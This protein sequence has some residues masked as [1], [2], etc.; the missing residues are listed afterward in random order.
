MLAVLP[1]DEAR[2][3]TARRRGPRGS[4]EYA[5]VCLIV[6]NNASVRVVVGDGGLLK[7]G[8]MPS[9]CSVE[10]MVLPRIGVSLSEHEAARIDASVAAHLH[11]EL[12]LGIGRLSRL[13]PPAH[14]ATAPDVHDEAEVQVPLPSAGA[15]RQHERMQ[16]TLKHETAKPRVPTSSRSRNA[17][18]RFSKSSTASGRRRRSA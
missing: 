18:T 10:T 2:D 12:D 4:C 8:T 3:S 6:R 11:D 9:H 5:G 15:R 1:S 16:R 14:D 17:S 7:K 13:Y